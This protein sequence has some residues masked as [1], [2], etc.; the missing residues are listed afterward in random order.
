MLET[1]RQLALRFEQG[2]ID[3][4]EFQTMM[5]IHARELIAE[6]EEDHQNPLAAW[7]ETRRA[8]AAVKKL[9]KK[10]TAFQVREVL[11]ALSE[12]DDFPM[13]KYLWNASH[14]DVPLHCFFRIGKQ[15][16]FKILSIN[17]KGD[18]VETQVEILEKGHRL[19]ILL[20]RD[21]RWRL[22]APSF[23]KGGEPA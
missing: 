15:P 14:P 22:V 23:S 17:Q 4:T 2:E 10:N 9:L 19:S 21:S 18:H 8:T 11:I 6:I 20:T 7:L 3:R 5:A 13:A 1:P 16:Y 12:A